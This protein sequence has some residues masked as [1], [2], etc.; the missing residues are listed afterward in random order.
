MDK[1]IIN[2]YSFA[3]KYC[4]IFSKTVRYILWLAGEE[5]LPNN[6]K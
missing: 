1:K 5:Y 3:S 4:T 2:F 6:Y